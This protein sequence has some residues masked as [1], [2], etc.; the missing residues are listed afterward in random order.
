MPGIDSKHNEN[1]FRTCPPAGHVNPGWINL[2]ANNVL[3]KVKNA[4]RVPALVP[5]VA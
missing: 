5:A 2:S 3:A 1:A 4:F